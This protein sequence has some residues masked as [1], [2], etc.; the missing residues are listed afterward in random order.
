MWRV[1]S[2][3]YNQEYYHTLYGVANSLTDQLL[4]SREISGILTMFAIG[5]VCSE[6]SLLYVVVCEDG[7]LMVMDGRAEL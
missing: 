5:E 1:E 2:L 4:R 3:L 6:K 7:K